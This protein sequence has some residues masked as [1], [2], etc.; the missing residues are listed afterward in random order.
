M[1]SFAQSLRDL[2]FTYVSI[3]M[4]RGVSITAWRGSERKTISV[5]SLPSVE[6]AER[7]F[8]LKLNSPAVDFEDLL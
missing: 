3:D 8:M 2:G 7:A 5:W 4:A 1:T 6:A